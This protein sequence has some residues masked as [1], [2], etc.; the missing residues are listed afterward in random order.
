MYVNVQTIAWSA[1]ELVCQIK[2]SVAT[3]PLADFLSPSVCFSVNFL[4]MWL[5]DCI[6]ILYQKIVIRF[7]SNLLLNYRK[8]KWE[9]K[10]KDFID[11]CCISNF[12]QFL[13]LGPDFL[14][15][16]VSFLVYCIYFL[17]ISVYQLIITLWAQKILS[18]LHSWYQSSVPYWSRLK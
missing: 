12:I 5:G 14:C 4:M 13:F 9:N 3:T 1:Y 7:K 17:S 18:N 11:Y 15:T 10:S 6:I 16:I 2:M 8:T